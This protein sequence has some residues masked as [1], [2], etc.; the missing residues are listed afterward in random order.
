MAHVM[1]FTRASCGHMFAHFDRRAEHI[2]NENLNRART[3][4][5][6]NLAVHQTMEQ[7]EFV[8]KRCSEVHCQNRKDVNV[9]VS[10]VVTA[11]K[12]LP[13]LREYDF[14]RATYEFLEKRY[15]R[16]NVVSAYVHNDEVTPHIHF[17]F[18]PVTEDKKRGGY[19]VS[20]KEVVNRRDLQTFHQDLSNF[21]EKKLGIE[22]GILNE[23]TKQGNKSIEQ[24]KRQ[25]A[26]EQVEKATQ[27]A[28]RIVS[29]AWEQAEG[30]NAEYQA[31]RAYIQS[32]DASSEVSMMYPDYAVV[33][34]SL[35]G[36]ETV[37]VPK[38]KW[39]EK[40]ISAH[41][42]RY[43][44]QATERFESAVMEFKNTTTAK[45][46]D[47]LE[48]QITSLQA[49]NS[50]LKMENRRLQVVVKRQKDEADQILEQVNDTL[51]KVSPHVAGQFVS[52]WNDIIRAQ[53][54]NW[55]IEMD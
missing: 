41:E 12:D 33:K 35:F 4:L 48:K 13:A 54:H 9:M 50:S 19:K 46:I 45:H 15:G 37:T 34:K 11:P 47:A 6:Y 14:F 7:G 20:A 49:Q 43:L 30:I 44:S 40:F 23:A 42:K 18:V 25:S 21:V 27:E 16:E 52:Q 5:N 8:R 55:E 1:K 26:I 2:S 51:A 31:K 39:E 17:A 3:Y 24:L 36:K 53:N 22:I 10:W 32:C 38:E 28:A 29:M